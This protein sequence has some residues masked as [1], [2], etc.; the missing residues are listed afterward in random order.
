MK[1]EVR[2]K[3]TKEALDQKRCAGKKNSRFT[4]GSGGI[5]R[6]HRGPDLSRA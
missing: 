1:K 6:L 5:G 3:G 4:L 2:A